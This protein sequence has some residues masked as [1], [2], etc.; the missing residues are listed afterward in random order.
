[1]NWQNHIVSDREVLLGKPTI[2]GTR[3]SVEFIVSLLAQGWNESEILSN[4][5]RLTKENLQAVFAY[6]QDCLQDGL[7]YSN[8]KKSA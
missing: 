6:L 8:I 7:L 4:H 3:I 1:V 2:N 5:P